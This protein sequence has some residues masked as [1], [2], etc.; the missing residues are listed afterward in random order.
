[1]NIIRGKVRA[2]RRVLIYGPHGIGK[3]TWAAAAP[4]ALLLATEDGA[5]D[6]GVDRSPTLARYGDVTEWLSWTLSQPHDYR[7]LVVDSLDWLERVIHQHV[8]RENKRGSIEEIPYGKGYILA[9]EFWDF[10]ISTW[11]EIRK[12]RGMAIILVSHA[13]IVKFADP[14]TDTYDRYEPDLD[15]RISSRLQEWCDEVLFA[16]YRI[17]TVKRDEG[18]NRSRTRAVGDCD[19]V[20][21]TA[22]APTHLAKRRCAMPDELPLDFNAYVA[23]LKQSGSNGNISGLVVDGHSQP[24]EESIDGKSE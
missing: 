19:R 1:M 10:L 23:C 3:T 18:F 9:L 15:K 22:E 6:V 7:T 24:K 21:H 14:T 17:N 16:A 13:R 12:Q 20:L 5:N 4:K 8:A 11:D 2:P